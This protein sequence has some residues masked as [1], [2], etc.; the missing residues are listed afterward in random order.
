MIS[1]MVKAIEVLG[2]QR[3]SGRVKLGIIKLS[4][5]SSELEGKLYQ[6]S[7]SSLVSS[8]LEESGGEESSD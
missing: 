7:S 3:G 8:K 6:V 4:S 5:S 2:R 1:G